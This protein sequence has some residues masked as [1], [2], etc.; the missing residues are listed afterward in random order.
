MSTQAKRRLV[1][2]GAI[3]VAGAA[4]AFIAMGNVGQNLVYYWTPSDLL[5]KG[6]KAYGTTVRLGG[7]VVPGTMKWDAK[8]L[9][10]E[11]SVSDG[12]GDEGKKVAVHSTGAPPQMFREGIGVVVEGTYD[13]SGVFK[14][15]RL[16]V[17]HSNEYR[18]PKP[19]EKVENFGAKTMVDARP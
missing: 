14:S 6:E 19:G 17:N 4:L 10:L 1:L 8:S 13:K 2:A 12:H 9:N 7:V 11:F 5:A 15:D 3:V 18:P 16:M